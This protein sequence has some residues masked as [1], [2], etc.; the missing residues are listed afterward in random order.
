MDDMEMLARC[1]KAWAQARSTGKRCRVYTRYIGTCGD[2]PF[3][4]FRK[5]TLE[6]GYG[7]YLFKSG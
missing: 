4:Y 6:H 3:S 7:R 5:W 1:E 2:C